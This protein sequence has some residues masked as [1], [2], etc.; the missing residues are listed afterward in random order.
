MYHFQASFSFDACQQVALLDARRSLNLNI[1]LH[2][3]PAQDFLRCL[4]LGDEGGGLG[5]GE[6]GGLGERLAALAAC[7]PDEEEMGTLRAF[8][9]D[10]G[11]LGGAERFCLALSEVPE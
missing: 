6:G 11:R 10:R 2:Q 3:F 7:L 8:K 4:A 5:G 9:G 1:F